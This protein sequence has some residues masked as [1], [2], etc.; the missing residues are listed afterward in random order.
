MIKNEDQLHHLEIL[1]II[2]MNIQFYITLTT[3]IN[4]HNNCLN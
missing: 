4:L 1:L 3:H 2:L